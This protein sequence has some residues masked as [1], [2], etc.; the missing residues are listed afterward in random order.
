[1]SATCA[2]GD[3]AL[4]L[5][6]RLVQHRQPVAHRA[7]GGAG[8]QVQRGGLDRHALLRGDAGEMRRQFGDPHPAQVEALAA[9]QHGDRHFADF[10]RGE[11][12]LHVRR[13]FLQR[14][15][16]RVEG[17]ARQHVD[18]VDD[19]DLG[20]G[21]HRAGAADLDDLAH[22]VDAGAR[23]GVHLEH[24]RLAL[25]QDGEAVVA[26]AAGIGGRAAGAVG[27][28][29]VQRAGDD[30][31][32]GG[33]A[34]AAH[35]GQHEG[36][37]DPA[38]GEGVAQDAHHRLLAD[39]VVERR[40]PV[41]ARQH[42]I[43]AACTGCGLGAESP[44]S[45][46]PSGGGGASSCWRIV[47]EQAG[48]AGGVS[49]RGGPLV[50]GDYTVGG[51]QTTRAETR[52]GCFLPDLTGLARRPSA[53]DLPAVA[54]HGSGGGGQ[55][56][57]AILHAWPT[58]AAPVDTCDAGRRR[59]TPNTAVRPVDC[60]NEGPGDIAAGGTCANSA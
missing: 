26:D 4:G 9:R 46:G 31:G 12:E 17:V 49:R 25:G 34:D 35:A 3:R 48:H 52:C 28:D 6:D 15:Q 47:L 50:V 13:R 27:P 53:A 38:G 44:N 24:V 10:R 42:P 22:V 14:L 23:G 33:F 55:G 19:E 21:L 58:R 32:G 2:V 54:Y 5:G 1:M 45:P 40:R 8:D 41:F 20:A 56:G 51:R 7:V 39:Q 36:V 16:Q 11:D 30:A 43:G 37:R 18:F 29:A 59:S 60:H 57:V